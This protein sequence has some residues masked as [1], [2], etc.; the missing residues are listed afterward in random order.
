M[1]K[2]TKIIFSL[3]FLATIASLLAINTAFADD[4]GLELLDNQELTYTPGPLAASAFC[5]VTIMKGQT[6]YFFAESVGG[7]GAVSF[8]WYQGTTMLAGQTDMV[9]AA[10]QSAAGTYTYTCQVTDEAGTTVTTNAI[11]LTVI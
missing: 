3:L 9:L 1:Q 2:T 8:Q 10:T 7:V 4:S 5:S 11:I 6:W